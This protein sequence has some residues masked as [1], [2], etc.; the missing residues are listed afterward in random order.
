MAWLG[1]AWLANSGAFRPP[2][3]FLLVWGT[4]DREAG[5]TQT[6]AEPAPRAPRGRK[7]K[8]GAY[9]WFSPSP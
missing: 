5:D 6:A 2:F 4:G 3:K 7:P 1:V 9:V 8:A